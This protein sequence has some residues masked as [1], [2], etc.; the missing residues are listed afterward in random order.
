MISKNNCFKGFCFYLPKGETT[1]SKSIYSCESFCI[2]PS[3]L[4][5]E[6]VNCLRKKN[7]VSPLVQ[8]DI[9]KSCFTM[10]F[11]FLAGESHEQIV[12]SSVP[13]LVPKLAIKSRK[14][15]L[16]T[17]TS[18]TSSY[19][20]PH[21]FFQRK[22]QQNQPSSHARKLQNHQAADNIEREIF[23]A[24]VATAATTF[25]FVA[26]LFCCWL[27]FRSSEYRTG[28]RIGQRDDRPL[29][30]LSGLSASMC[31]FLNF[32]VIDYYKISF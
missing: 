12:I 5:Q 11:E 26:S 1:N 23:I 3:S 4:K 31:F 2:R 10:C 15:S 22:L 20:L 27:C 14:Y 19:P 32:I 18:S 8:W 9:P 24:V 7:I 6:L 21:P 29:L 25:F 13:Y 16:S 28:P 17:P 30:H